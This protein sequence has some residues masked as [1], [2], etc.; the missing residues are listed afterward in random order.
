MGRAAA[1]PPPIANPPPPDYNTRMDAF[2]GAQAARVAAAFARRL[3][4]SGS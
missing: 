2:A 1:P 3:R 4:A